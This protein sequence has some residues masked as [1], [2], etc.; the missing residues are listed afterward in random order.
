M[1]N[2]Y[3]YGR[4]CLTK[5]FLLFIVLTGFAN[6]SIAQYLVDF[7]AE[8]GTKS[9]YASETVT[10]SG[11]EWD[12]TQALIGSLDADWKNGEWSAR[13]RGYEESSMTML[14][15]KPNGLGTLSFQYRRYGT[16]TQV[17]WKVEYSTDAGV[18]WIQVGDDFTAPASDDV[19]TFSEEVNVEGG[20]RIR[21]MR[22][23]LDG[24][25][26]NRRL[27]IDDILLTDYAPG[28]PSL[29][30]VPASITD[31]NYQEGDGPSSSKSF[32]LSG[33]NLD[34]SDVTIS[35]PGNFEVSLDDA[36]FSSETQIDA[37]D[38]SAREVYV[39]LIENLGVDTYEGQVD[40]IGGGA[41]LVQVLVSGEVVAPAQTLSIPYSNP[42][43]TE[44]DFDDA[45]DAGF[46]IVDANQETGAGGYLRISRDGY[47]ETPPIDFTLND[48][49]LVSF[50]A[51]TW[52]GGSGR[53]MSI[54]ISTDG[55]DTYTV[56]KEADVTAATPDY[57]TVEQAIDLSGEY[58]VE[59]GKLRFEMTD[60]TGRTRF[61]DFSIEDY[62]FPDVELTAS[63]ESLSGF[64]YFEGEGPSD[65]QSFQISGFGLDNTDVT[66]AAPESFEVSDSETG[67]YGEDVI[68]EVYDGTETT[69]W[70]RLSEG[71]SPDSY[72]GDIAITGGG[73]DPVSV[74]VSGEVFEPILSGNML[75]R[76]PILAAGELEAF[77]VD[78]ISATD[79][80]ISDGD[81]IYGSFQDDTWEGPMPYAQ[82]NG[83]WDVENP[84]EAK[85][86]SFAISGDEGYVVTIDRIEFE[87]RATNQGP[88]AFTIYANGSEI[89][90]SD[91]PD[92]ETR[93][94]S[95]EIAG[96]FSEVEF[97]FAGWDNGSRST[98]GTGQWRVNDFTVYGSIQEGA[99]VEIAGNA[100]WRMLSIP[101]DG[102][103]VADLAA[104]NQV[105]GITGI[106]DFYGSD[107]PGD[108]ETVAPN[109]FTSYE[110]GWN[111]PDNVSDVLE[112]GRGL[113]WYFFNNDEGVSTPLPFTLSA[114]GA[115]PESDVSTSLHTS[116]E[117]L[118]DGDGGTTSVAFNLLGN[119]F[120]ADL[121]ISDIENW[122]DGGS[123]N[124]SIVQVWKNDDAGWQEGVGHQGEWVLI[125]G[126][127]NDDKVA[128]WQGFMVE[129]VDAT[130]IEYPASAR[131]DGA[132]FLK[133]RKLAQ[134][135]VVF[136]LEGEN[137]EAGLRTRD[138]ANLVFA[139]QAEEGWD[140]L[141]ATQ[142]TP[143]AGSY[144]TL[145]FVGE[146]NEQPVLKVQES[147]PSEFEGRFQIPMAFNPY[148]MG[149]DFTVSWDGLP[150]L[151]SDWQFTLTDLHTGQ[152]VNLREADKYAFS[153]EN[154]DQ[155]RLAKSVGTGAAF[156]EV[157]PL[158]LSEDE[159]KDV[160]E[161]FLLIVDSEPLSS[162]IPGDVPQKL[163]LS[164]NYP[165]PFNP[166]TVIS[167]TVPEQAHIR[168][169]VYDM[170]GREISVLVNEQQGPG[171]YDVTWD[172][173]E[174]TSGMYLYR[175]EA[176][177]KSITRR[178]TFIK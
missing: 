72:S 46:V 12:M 9:A 32:M 2:K 16:D 81:I 146:V 108:I 145:S 84:L 75:V 119:P 149:G 169:T 165:N 136:T 74:S 29:V 130:S 127:N 96:S 65:P 148:N 141:D 116:S 163:E 105:Q 100:G 20:V 121:D 93:S 40:V 95:F 114:T 133:D 155:S 102:A 27:N 142:L 122:V 67:T 71:L 26:N 160:G 52:G 134:K 123:L 80:S 174:F 139:E 157:K 60:G 91:V 129:N 167:Y 58:N 153:Y 61:R 64:G 97:R 56:L 39:R 103:T 115:S 166:S 86:F 126:G 87:E 63:P 170:L 82:A 62:E 150:D 88:S 151:P 6:L 177:S 128:A 111:A 59:D 94:H 7:E 45:I 138:A 107:A 38:G 110:A 70:V 162:E 50:D 49:I 131:T 47:V 106:A 54:K 161:R 4:T 13:F 135:R 124:S 78:N 19:Q 34:G 42:F 55:G 48:A 77:T 104:Q 90:T 178:M 14:E 171:S 11:L 66:V 140:L 176:G 168:L 36:A 137:T 24:N 10:L 76:Y 33:S 154:G 147:R 68:L 35:A 120:A 144:A 109:I 117:Q 143:L 51:A 113:L 89:A 83:G 152:S 112:V 173:T 17:D 22:A 30:T 99:S 15:D 44:E 21:I 172:G 53:V 31:L 92:S 175:L 73:A 18:T 25:T 8:G 156:S 1:A 98:S 118:D 28:I 5:L 79:L 69:L 159:K 101:V 158:V 125:G 43:R 3:G 37:Y 41:G 23:T 57:A 164:Q 132:T 85:Y